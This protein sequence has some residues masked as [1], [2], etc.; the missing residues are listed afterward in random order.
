MKTPLCDVCLSS[1][2]LCSGCQ[3]R[4]DNGKLTQIDI[5]VSRTLFDLSKTNRSLKDITLKKAVN[6]DILLLVSA[7]G[8]AP[9]LVGKKGM[10]VKK[11]AKKFERSL[12]IIDEGKFEEFLSD[13]LAPAQIIGINVAFNK[14]GETHKVRVHN[15][16]KDKISI[17]GKGFSNIMKELYG[18]NA[19]LVFE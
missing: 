13:I 12:K 8:D 19:K 17:S 15:S 14:D 16:F 5:D 1:D 10:V 11:L 18:K 2:I 7:I 9:K 4:L 6:S 3:Q